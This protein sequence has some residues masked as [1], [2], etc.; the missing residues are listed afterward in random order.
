MTATDWK[1]RGILHPQTGEANFQL[2][3]HVPAPAVSTFVE[4]YWIIQWDLRGQ[5]AY[6]AET[7]PQPYV[8]IVF[9]PGNARI[10][11][12]ASQKYTN[13]LQGKGQVFGIKFKPGAFYPLL[14]SPLAALTDRSLPVAEVLGNEANA[15]ADTILALDD[16]QAMIALADDFWQTRLPPVDETMT[17][18]QQIVARIISD[19]T[20]TRVEALADLFALN[21]RTLQRLF[22]QYVGVTPKWV[23]RRYRLHEAAEQLSTGANVNLPTLALALGYFDQAHFSK[24]FKALIGVSPMQY[25]G[26]SAGQATKQAA[27]ET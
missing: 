20:I 12:V 10:Y 8:N 21:K 23:I 11:G 24:D 7:L 13:L 14:K 2:T 1:P 6:Q 5:P 17:R 9:E 3:R 15:L 16:N 4:R 25:A 22:H 19:R 27:L 18:I 26:Q